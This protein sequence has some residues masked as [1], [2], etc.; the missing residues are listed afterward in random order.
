MKIIT[1][2]NTFINS[3]KHYPFLYGLIAGLYPVFFYYSNNYA[4]VNSSKHFVFFITTFLLLPAISF[5]IIFAFFSIKYL[6]KWQKYVL[7]F[8]TV[9]TFL[10]LLKVSLY[11][12]VQKKI[13]LAIFF[14]SIVIAYF[15]YKHLKKIVGFQL[16]LATIGLISLVPTVIKQL[17]FS[18]AWKKQPDDI[19]QVVFK[20]KPNI[21]LIQPDGYTNPS[22][23]KKGYYKID[24]HLFENYLAENKFEI[25]PD[26]RSNYY[27]TLPTNSSLFMMK[28]HYYNKG[29]NDEDGMDWRKVI[30]SNN[31]VLDIFK[32]N[33]YKTYFLSQGGYFFMNYPTLGYD[34]SNFSTKD[35]DLLT[36]GIDKRKDFFPDLISILKKET[37]APKFIFMRVY[38]P[39]H[40]RSV[41]R[42]ARGA[43]EEKKSWEENLFK[44]N[45][46]LQKIIDLIIT[47][48]PQGII[49]IMADHGGYVGFDSTDQAHEKTQDRDKKASIFSAILALKTTND[50][51]KTDFKTYVKTPVNL[52]RVLF[53]NLSE[54]NTYKNHL[55]NNK[56]YMIIY[57][58]APKG[59]YSY[60][61]EEGNSIFEKL[62]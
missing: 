3:N 30:I 52:F 40:I 54:D 15:F 62:K 2:I 58:N 60:F 20:K 24:N 19:A 34:Y 47:T 59:I 35:I 57:K 12:G 38:N 22:E 49:I 26:F 36:Q 29:T 39:R 5:K 27:A 14:I 41:A 25:Y 51:L 17:S 42:G 1:F 61:D 37:T 7:P 9:F 13:S 43:Q 32:N 10:F 16:L 28:H 31:T 23:L 55:E 50:S 11:A 33:G 45:K 6:K 18:E 21:Y 4:L 44:G 53:A 8:L 56:S 48:D 46:E